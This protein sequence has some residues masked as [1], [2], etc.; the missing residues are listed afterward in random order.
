MKEKKTALSPEGEVLDRLRMFEESLRELLRLSESGSGSRPVLSRRGTEYIYTTLTEDVCRRCP[1]Y[2]ECFGINKEK[3]FREIAA[4]LEQ[5]SKENRVDG[6]MAS[7]IF[8]K[9]CVYFQPFMEEMMWLF[10][11]L[12]QN[13]CWERQLGGLR[14]VMKKQLVSQYM[15]MQECRRLLSDGTEVT[16]LKKRRLTLSLLRR[17]FRLLSAREY[18]DEAGIFTVTLSL[19]PVAGSRKVTGVLRALAGVYG[20]AFRCA[21]G[22]TWVRSGGSRISFVEEGGF[23]VS[24]GVS[25][26][27]KKGETVCGDTFSFTNYNKK[28]AVMLLS[29]GMGVG[30]SAGRDSRQLIEAFE[31]MLEAGIH[32]EYALEIL[33]DVLLGREKAEYA[34]L[35]A[36]VISLQTGTLRLLKAGGT[37][38]FIRH[39]QSVERILPSGLPPG[40]LTEQRFDIHSKKLYDGDMV[41][42]LSDGMLNFETTAGRPSMEEILLGIRPGSAQRFAEELMKAAPEEDHDDD[43]TVLVAVVRDFY[44]PGNR[45]PVQ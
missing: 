14:Q 8:R 4:I 44:R 36:A 45:A 22:D 28:K 25:R 41:I 26:R 1:K 38:T 33:H 9:Q 12:Y 20:R 16:G 29:D 32:E 34:T 10:R 31:T 40:C 13:H 30:E 24:F 7:G 27:S 18:T 17:G 42:M 2:R 35:D 5:A 3:T 21:D 37:A 19:R 6:R 39:R 15:L 23:Q 11:M 43:R